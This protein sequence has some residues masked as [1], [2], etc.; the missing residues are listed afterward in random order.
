MYKYFN[1]FFANL[2]YGHF[3]TFGFQCL[4]G[5]LLFYRY[6]HILQHGLPDWRQPI[7]YYRRVR[8]MGVAELSVL[9]CIIITI[10]HYLVLWA[11]YLEK[12]LALVSEMSHVIRKPT[13]WFP[14]GLDT[15]LAV[16]AQ[17]MARGWTIWIL[18]VE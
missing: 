2:I 14:N 11:V 10:G 6:N 8:K 16:Q 17:K 7:F 5:L 1:Y 12:R 13:M 15:N 4:N 3:C 9:L 18:K